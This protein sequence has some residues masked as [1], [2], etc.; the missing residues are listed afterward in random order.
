MGH[1]APCTFLSR[2]GRFPTPAFPAHLRNRDISGA[3]SCGFQP[4][5]LWNRNL[6]RSIV[7][8]F[9]VLLA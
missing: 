6:L 5:H 2:P 8:A 1:G 9:R 7:K 3:I 4:L